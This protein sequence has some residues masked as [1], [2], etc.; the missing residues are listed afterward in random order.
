MN[1]R[2]FR[3]KIALLS[4]LITG[5]LL[6][7]SGVVL[8]QLTYGT[9]LAR[10]DREIRNLGAPQLERVVGGD[11]WIRFENALQFVAGTN[12]TP[13]FIL[14]VKIEDRVIH[15]S[16]HWPAGIAPES[17]PPLQTYEKPGALKPGQPLPPP[18]RVKVIPPNLGDVGAIGAPGV[19]LTSLDT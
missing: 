18:P 11:H 8:W 6:V 12:A 14:W 7:G 15:Q 10:I 16:S 13:A 2:S 1:L 4:G 9:E 3:L 19:A 17:L 5:L